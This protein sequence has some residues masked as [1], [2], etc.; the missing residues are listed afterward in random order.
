MV[1]DDAEVDRLYDEIFRFAANHS[2]EVTEVRED[3]EIIGITIE[4]DFY[5]F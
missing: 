3:D 2:I 1:A 5:R 4:D